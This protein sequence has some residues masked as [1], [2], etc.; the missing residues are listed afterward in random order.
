MDDTAL[1][2]MYNCSACMLCDSSTDQATSDDFCS[3]ACHNAWHT[4]LTLTPGTSP[5]P[6]SPENPEQMREQFAQWRANTAA[7]QAVFVNELIVQAEKIRDL[8][9]L[10]IRQA[11]EVGDHD[12][13]EELLAA[14]PFARSSLGE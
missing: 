2:Q 5:R 13:A 9:V 11:R 7:S 4:M 10:Q 3:T 1:E 8:A 6:D 14:W 12:R